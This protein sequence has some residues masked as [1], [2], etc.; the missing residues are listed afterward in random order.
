MS[1]EIQEFVHAIRSAPDDPAPRLVFADWY[2]EEG[3]LDRAQLIRMQVERAA[4]PWWEADALRLELKERVLLA[5]NRTRWVEKLPAVEGA[6]YGSFASGFVDNIGFETLGR[7]VAN[8]DA[9]Q[10]NT[11]FSK[12]TLRWP[13]LDD[14]PEL[15][16]IEGLREVCMVGTV[17]QP[18]DV[19]WL[20][21]CPLLS[22]VDTLSIVGSAMNEEALRHLVK[23]PYLKQL[24][25]LRLPD[26]NFTDE[27]MA[28]LMKAELPA[29]REL[30]VSVPTQDELGS[31][32]RVEPTFDDVTAIGMGQ[33]PVLA[34][35]EALSITGHQIG[36]E[37][38][39]AL[40]SS[41]H[42]A[43]MK[44]LELKSMT[45]YDMETG[46]RPSDVF[47]VMEAANT[48]MRLDELDIGENELGSNEFQVIGNL[49][50]LQELKVL[51]LDT[52]HCDVSGFFATSWFKSSVRYVSVE[53]PGGEAVL[54][55]VLEAAP[56]K[57]H[58]ICMSSQYG[59]S[60]V[61]GIGDILADGTP[62]P[63][64]LHL[65][66]RGCTIE[67]DEMKTL[68]EQKTLPNLISLDVSSMWEDE[69]EG[70]LTD[71]ALSPLYSQLLCF[72]AISA[73]D[74]PAPVDAPKMKLGR[75]ASHD[76]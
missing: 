15:K 44:K 16:A 74:K 3:D 19:E 47:L 41:K 46:D 75:W 13:R 59:W 68:G 35:L 10:R 12:I 45:D 48:E 2:E 9:L 38:L 34:Q 7:L 53:N 31:G 51:R 33:W 1:N 23:S 11:P 58:S 5:S 67:E 50:A 17:M 28:M 4:L 14:R 55:E 52:M 39:K 25:A 32:G 29:L 57:L 72:T 42:L 18:E 66:L 54:A 40:V 64:V 56:E 76:L 8:V 70:D 22:T 69:Y 71:L 30:D 27:G 6:I 21:N 62:L 24:R 43:K 65:D 26:H 63:S 49:P 36:A 73:K 20:A 37:G 60:E 61:S